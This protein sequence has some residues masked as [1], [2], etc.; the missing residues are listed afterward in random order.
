MILV[1][2]CPMPR[3]VGHPELWLMPDS[4]GTTAMPNLLLA[5]TGWTLDEFVSVFATRTYLWPARGQRWV[6]SGKATAK[7]LMRAGVP[8]VAVGEDVG[9]CFGVKEPW[10]W[11]NGVAMIPVPVARSKAWD[12]SRA[13]EFFDGVRATVS[14]NTNGATVTWGSHQ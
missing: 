7:R 3:L 2:D 12:L 13:R 8:I 6:S 11:K 4:S 1:G 14:A 10:R 5:A 9:L